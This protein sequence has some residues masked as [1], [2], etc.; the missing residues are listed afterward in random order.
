MMADMPRENISLRMTWKNV[1]ASSLSL[2]AAKRKQSATGCFASK[3]A[4]VS[5][6]SA[7]LN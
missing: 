7:R 4:R 5:S 2:F 1:C 3:A 6:A